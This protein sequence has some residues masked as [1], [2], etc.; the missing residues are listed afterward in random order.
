M[1][2]PPTSPQKTTK[3]HTESQET[4]SCTGFPVPSPEGG[5]MTT[6]AATRGRTN[7][8]KGADTER[9]VAKYLRT[10]GFSNTER[11]VRTGYT[12]DDRVVADPLDITGIPGTVWSV[13]NDASNQ[14]AKWLSEAE[15]LGNIHGA[16]L[17]I[18]VVRRKGKADVCRWWSWVSLPALARVLIGAEACRDFHGHVCLE[19]D[20]LVPM[21]HA[22]GFGDPPPEKV[23]GGWWFWPPKG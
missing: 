19:L 16:E 5:G 23:H 11:A 13:K 22:A 17:A 6:A 12:V 3:A 2:N 7:R 4:A 15:R 10:V 8:R 18:L 9:A 21:L 1:E 20:N 14:I